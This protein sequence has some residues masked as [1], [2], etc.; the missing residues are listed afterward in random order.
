MSRIRHYFIAGLLIILPLFVTFY[1][2]FII[3]RFIDGLS[4]GFINSYLQKYLGFS[5]PGA[6]FIV[7]IFFVLLV[8]FFTTH[9]LGKRIPSFF[10]RWLLRFPFIR[11]VYPPA[12]QIIHFFVSKEKFSFRQV[13]MIEYPCKGIWSVGFITNEGF[14][15]A[16]EKTGQELLHVFIAT[17]PGPFSGFLVLV[18]K[19]D[20]K[21]LDIP[22]ED[23]L[24]LIVSGGIINPGIIDKAPKL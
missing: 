4:G 13:V 19:K 22:V 8:G 14:K 11:Q 21:F 7:G 20:V 15:E 16:E 5:I 1:L 2:L 24:K 9:F 23:G 12:K 6:G 10:E 3:F 18:P 17:T